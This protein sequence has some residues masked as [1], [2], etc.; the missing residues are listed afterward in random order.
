MKERLSQKSYEHFTMA[1]KNGTSPDESVAIDI[2][3]AVKEWAIEQGV[4]HFTHWFQ[5]QRNETAE[6]HDA[7]ISYQR[8]WK[9]N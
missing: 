9:S 2:A 4:T 1:I 8:G 3:H 5:P 7:F 6:K